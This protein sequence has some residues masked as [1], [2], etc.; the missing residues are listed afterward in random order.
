MLVAVATT[1]F[2]ISNSLIL[3]NLYTYQSQVNC[4]L[5]AFMPFCTDW[6]EGGK[7]IEVSIKERAESLFFPN[8]TDR[9]I[10]LVFSWFTWLP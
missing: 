9:L 7:R 2:R 6:A 4:E 1:L 10:I 8:L 5:G 3:E